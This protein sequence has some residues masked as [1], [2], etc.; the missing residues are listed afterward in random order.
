MSSTKKGNDGYFWSEADQKSIRGID[1]PT[2]AHVGVDADSGVGHSLG[3]LD[4]KA[5]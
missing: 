1:F 2:R 4:G 5:A 3:Y